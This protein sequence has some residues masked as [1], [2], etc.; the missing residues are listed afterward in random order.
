MLRADQPTLC[1]RCHAKPVVAADGRTIGAMG[2]GLA[3]AAMTHG[4]VAMGQCSQCHSVHGA[5]HARLLKDV[6]GETLSEGVDA[7]NYALCFSCHDKGLLAALT[8]AATQFRDGD[9][10]LHRSHLAAG[11][12]RSHGC[13][14]CHNAHGAD[15]PK[16]I[17]QA[18]PYQG[19]TWLMPMG[20]EITPDG[21]SCSPGCHEAISYSRR[22]GGVKSRGGGP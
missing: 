18:V 17:A 2:G 16:L 11:A 15:G 5:N 9:T 13:A 12:G 6:A 3:A 1:L 21:G 22:P 19:S 8:A 14:A 20:F 10:N 4:P 7:R